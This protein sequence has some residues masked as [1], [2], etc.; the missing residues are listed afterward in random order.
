MIPI[1]FSIGCFISTYCGG[2]IALK[3]N[4]KKHLLLAFCAGC[5]SSVALFD[6]LPQSA[7]LSGGLNPTLIC[8]AIGFFV[9]YTI[10]NLVP[11]I[12]KGDNCDTN[13]CKTI[14]ATSALSLHSLMD[15]LA[16][17]L[18][19]KISPAIFWPVALGISLH[20]ISDGLNVVTQCDNK[21]LALKWLSIDALA[22]ILGVGIA[23]MINIPDKIS[24]LLLGL[25]AGFFMYIGMATLI[26]ECSH[27]H[28]KFWNIILTGLGIVFIYCVVKIAG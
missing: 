1:L 19:F 23:L 13:K 24:G 9:Y 15:G 11:L 3:W 20:D 2:L 18:A 14:L 8:V 25:F 27:S 4:D 26:P 16:I 12:S 10:N 5:V 22:P 21:P 17:G 7:Q 28:S 6:L